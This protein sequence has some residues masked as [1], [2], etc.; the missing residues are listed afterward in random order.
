MNKIDDN[1]AIRG[2]VPTASAKEDQSDSPVAEGSERSSQVGDAE[3]SEP[4][5]H[6]GRPCVPATPA[7]V[8]IGAIRPE[9]DE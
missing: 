8:R 6:G 2:E 4:P 7:Q 5:G 1:G 3:N 9:D